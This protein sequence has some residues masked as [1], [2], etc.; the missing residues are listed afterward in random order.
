MSFFNLT[1]V[2]RQNVFQEY[3]KTDTVLPPIK[4]I[5]SNIKYDT[6]KTKHVRNQKG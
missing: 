6:L 2:G 5:D 1:M 3:K 4:P